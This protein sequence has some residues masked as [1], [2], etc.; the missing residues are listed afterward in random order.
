MAVI[1]EGS[2]MYRIEQNGGYLRVK[3]E[4]DFDCKD[5]QTIIRHVTSIKAYPHTNDIWIIGKH[6]ADIRLGELEM[7]MT[8]F[9]CRCSKDATRTKTAV[10]VEPGVT[11]S[12]IELWV[13]ATNKRVQFEMR[14]FHSLS[15][16]EMW[17]E[18]AEEAL[19]M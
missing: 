3:F 10:V 5:V 18:E 8:E 11:A 4:K 2:L 7:M 14:L 9:H 13:S 15:E 19:A 1:R 16:A 6:H 17:L 12:I